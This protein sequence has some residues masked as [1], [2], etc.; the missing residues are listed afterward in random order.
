MSKR[1][2]PP[3]EAAL[4]GAEQIG[5]TIV[6]LTVSLIA[7]LIPLLFMSDIVGRLF[8]EFAV[9]LSVTILVSALVSLTLTPMMCARMLRQVPADQEGRLAQYLDASFEPMKS[10]YD[11]SLVWVLQRQRAALLV[12][13]ATLVVTAL[14]F[15]IVPKGFFPVQDTGLITGVTEAPQ[16]ISFAGLVERQ[17]ALVKALVVDPAVES[18]SSFVGVDG[19]NVT[20]NSGRLQINLKPVNERPD[21]VSTV[22]R[23][24]QS[25]TGAVSGITLY[26]QAV[27]DLEVE[28]RVSRTQYQFSLEHP[29][30]AQLD[31]WAG[32]LL[33]ALRHESILQDVATDQ[34]TGGVR[35]RCHR[36]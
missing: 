30:Q 8:R 27:Q 6:S 35:R 26:M 36:S 16:T 20:P 4:Q 31:L 21:T 14:L 2:P 17:Q 25:R 23:R 18:L 10:A 33:D 3:L 1:A 34:Q 24:L 28:D 19:T 5:F 32:R 29:D 15:A 12:F 13:G 7:V 22:I 11:R 9:T